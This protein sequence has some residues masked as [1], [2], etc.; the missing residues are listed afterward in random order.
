MTGVVVVETQTTLVTQTTDDLSLVVVEEPRATKALH[1][2]RDYDVI[3]PSAP[4]IRFEYLMPVPQ[5]TALIDHNL[6]Y[7]PVAIQV[8][9]TGSGE[10]F[11]EWSAV[12]TVPGQQIRLGFDVAVAALIR[13]A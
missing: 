1:N 3:V 7:D 8:L 2:I 11:A 12:F 5:T 6:G 4:M 9:D 13:L 10:H